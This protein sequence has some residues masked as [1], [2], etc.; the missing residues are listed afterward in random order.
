MQ[1]ELTDQERENLKRYFDLGGFVVLDNPGANLDR[2]IAESSLKEMITETLGSQVRI[3]PLSSDHELYHCYFDF[4][5]GPPNG[6]EIEVVSTRSWFN[7]SQKTP[8]TLPDQ[9]SY[10]EGIWYK[11]RLAGVYSGKGYIVKWQENENNEPQL[12]IGIN[13]VVYSLLQQNSIALQRYISSNY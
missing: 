12:K 6:S 9:I 4:I 1:F 13:M 10:L 8:P 2:S 11:G 7:G 5:D 3:A